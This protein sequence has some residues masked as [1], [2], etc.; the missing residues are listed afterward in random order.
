MSEPV[1][2]VGGDLRTGQA[3]YLAAVSG[4]P[5]AP[6]G[7]TLTF[8]AERVAGQGPVNTFSAAYSASAT[9][10]L[11]FGPIASTSMAG[12]E[13]DM[14]AEAELLEILESVDGYTALEGG[15]LYLFDDQWQVL[16]FSAT[17]APADPEVPDSGATVG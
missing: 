9:G 5:G 15:E 3:W 11:T 7:V 13:E 2:P 1:R 6:S 16:T 10:S 4:S 17:P 8:E 14:Q 12:P